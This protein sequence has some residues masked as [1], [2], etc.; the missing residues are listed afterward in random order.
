MPRGGAQ[1][2]GAQPSA[3][4]AHTSALPTDAKTRRTR[5]AAAAAERCV[6][7]CRRPVALPRLRGNA[8]CPPRWTATQSP[9]LRTAPRSSHAPGEGRPQGAGGRSQHAGDRPAATAAAAAAAAAAAVAPAAAGATPTS[10]PPSP[11]PDHRL[12]GPSMAH[13]TSLFQ[14]DRL[15]RYRAGP[16]SS[17]TMTP[18]AASSPMPT[19]SVM[20]NPSPATATRHLLP[21]GQT[22]PVSHLTVARTSRRAGAAARPAQLGRLWDA[23]RLLTTA[24]TLSSAAAVAP[25]MARM[26]SHAAP[27]QRP[28]APALAAR[29]REG[30]VRRR[31]GGA[32]HPKALH[33]KA[34]HLD[35]MKVG[36]SASGRTANVSEPGS[37]RLNANSHGQTSAARCR[38]ARNRPSLSRAVPAH[39]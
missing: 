1:R 37:W 11:S 22:R 15:W 4:S 29:R 2:A 30:G 3:L 27:S 7:A 10:P 38:G 21:L 39:L 28:E 24:A 17:P 20:R 14:W 32:L 6:A 12:A 23:D 9:T 34:H 36:G 26:W 8:V 33:P 16:R 5:R 13:W 31:E 19:A 18:P 35:A 25:M